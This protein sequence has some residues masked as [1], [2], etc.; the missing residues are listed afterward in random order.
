MTQTSSGDAG[1]A[2]VKTQVAKQWD[3]FVEPKNPR[4]NRPGTHGPGPWYLGVYGSYT[5][6]GMLLTEVYPQTAAARAGLQV[7]DRILTVNGHQIGVVN[8]YRIPIDAALQR[9]ATRSGHVRLLVQDRNTMRLVNTDARLTR[10]GVHT[11]D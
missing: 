9:Y 1:P 6:T 3:G 11:I 7:G 10:S 4:P 2:E 5:S 8:G